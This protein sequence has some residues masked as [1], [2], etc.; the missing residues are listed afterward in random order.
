ML[1]LKILFTNYGFYVT[2]L[3]QLHKLLVNNITGL[4]G[5]VM[6]MNNNLLLGVAILCVLYSQYPEYFEAITESIKNSIYSVLESTDS[7]VL[8]GVA[9]AGFLYLNGEYKLI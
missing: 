4:K 9:L 3:E 5:L 6:L 7:L 8:I 2:Y 1:Q